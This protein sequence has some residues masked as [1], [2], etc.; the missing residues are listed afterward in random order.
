[1]KMELNHYVYLYHPNFKEV[2]K[3]RA[4]A[5]EILEEETFARFVRDSDLYNSAG[6]QIEFPDFSILE[7]GLVEERVFTEW[8][9]YDSKAGYFSIS[10]EHPQPYQ[11]TISA[12]LAAWEEAK[13]IKV[14][15]T[16]FGV[17]DQ[18]PR[19]ITGLHE[20][21]WH[22][23]LAVLNHNREIFLSL[24]KAGHPMEM[25]SPNDAEQAYK[26]A[27]ER[28]RAKG[29]LEGKPMPAPFKGRA[30]LPACVTMSQMAF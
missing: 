17:S 23:F 29:I 28:I 1:M 30:V 14:V 2:G 5:K 27:W 15:K 10:F 18:N 7:N 13:A 21:I 6:I 19:G 20:F 11:I 16:P 24:K 4:I 8:L 25:P 22:M 3:A 12:I 9:F 26:T